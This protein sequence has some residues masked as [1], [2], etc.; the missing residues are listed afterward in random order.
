MVWNRGSP[1]FSFSQWYQR[2][3]LHKPYF[4]S[5]FKYQ[6]WMYSIPVSTR[7]FC[8]VSLSDCKA[9]LLP[10]LFQYFSQL[11]SG[12]SL[13]HMNFKFMLFVLIFFSLSKLYAFATTITFYLLN[14]AVDGFKFG[15]YFKR[16]NF[17][18]SHHP[19]VFI[20]FLIN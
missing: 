10:I 17:G 14:W 8:F 12:I 9:S 15:Y 19:S 7:I 6:I 4:P 2:Q 16:T 13:I 5:K 11:F 18:Y 3:L 20:C 1:V